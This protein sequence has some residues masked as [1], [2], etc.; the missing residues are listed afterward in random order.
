MCK[1]FMCIY[2]YCVWTFVCIY[3][4]ACGFGHQSNQTSDRKHL[5]RPCATA[6][7]FHKDIV[8]RSGPTEGWD[9]SASGISLYLPREW[10]YPTSIWRKY[11]LQCMEMGETNYLLSEFNRKV[12]HMLATSMHL[13]N[14]TQT[15]T[16]RLR[17]HLSRW[18]CRTPK[19][20]VLCRKRIQQTTEHERIV[21]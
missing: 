20:D 17:R 10:P 6:S 13:S 16:V 21:P 7:L 8:V 1:Q 9:V 3:V 19:N 2:I 11:G 12:M 18:T 5:A 14:G 15:I 4:C